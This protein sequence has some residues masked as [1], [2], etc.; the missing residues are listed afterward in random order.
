MM[1]YI[2]TLPQLA[3]SVKCRQAQICSFMLVQGESLMSWPIGGVIQV[4]PGSD[5]AAVARCC[6]RGLRELCL[7]PSHC[8]GWPSSDLN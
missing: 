6:V 1:E 5:G 2:H 7:A 3:G 4:F 8:A